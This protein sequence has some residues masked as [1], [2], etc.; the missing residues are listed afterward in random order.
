MCSQELLA[1]VMPMMAQPATASAGP[2]LQ[3][4]NLQLAG[5]KMV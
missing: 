1:A 4:F 5:K 2:S 3:G